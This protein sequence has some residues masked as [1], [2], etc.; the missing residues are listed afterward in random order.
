[1]KKNLLYL[2]MLLCSVSMFTSC[3]DDDDNTGDDTK[4]NV[5]GT[6]AGNLAVTINESEPITTSQSIVLVNPAKGKINFSLK[7]FVLQAGASGEAG[8]TI[9]V[10]NINITDIDLV[11]SNNGTYT[12][13]KRV[14]KLKIEAGDLAG[15]EAEQWM[16]PILSA[17]GIPVT[18]S[19]TIT[20]NNIMLDITI[21]FLSMDI[22]VQF[23]GTKK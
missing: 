15:I 7:N 18:L 5:A 9:P 14:D 19:G 21:P 23:S 4:E 12:F 20:G 16:G 3:S 2:L 6:Y 17:Q 10:G 22:A 1:M 8:Q 11:E 13:T